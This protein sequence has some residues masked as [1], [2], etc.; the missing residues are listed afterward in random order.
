[1]EPRNVSWDFAPPPGIH[2]RPVQVTLSSP[3]PEGFEV[4]FTIDGTIPGAE[5]PRLNAPL[6]IEVNT[7]IRAAAFSGGQRVTRVTAAS[8]FIQERPPLPLFSIAIDPGKAYKLYFRKQYG[9]GKLRAPLF[10]DS[11]VR[12]FDALV[13]RSGYNDRFR[14]GRGDYN[15]RAA[16]LRDEVLREVHRDMGSVAVR[17][18]WCLL[19]VNME[20]RGLYNVVERPGD[21]FLA[22]HLGGGDW[23][24]IKTGDQVQSGSID[25]WVALLGV[26]ARSSPGDED[27]YREIERRVDLE[28]FTAYII[29]NHW[30]Q[31]H[32]WSY[33]NWY[34]ARKRAAGGRWIFLSWDAEWGLGLRP[35]G[36]EADS[37]LYHLAQRNS[38]R[39]LLAALLGHRKYRAFFL[40]KVKEHL[41]GALRPEKVLAHLARNREAIAPVMEEELRRFAGGYSLDSWRTNVARAESFARERGGVF[42]RQ[43]E[44]HLSEPFQL[45]VGFAQEVDFPVFFPQGA[46]PAPGQGPRVIVPRTRLRIQEEK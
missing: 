1:V 7:L 4:R 16:Y 14:A 40:E 27:S 42:L 8:Y 38:I 33:N 31:N 22:S 45:P 19:Y 32:D 37:F 44:S 15:V 21:E 24:V 11:P 20:P 25:E 2:P 3:L 39:D 17:G 12:E 6:S 28:N 36:W 46:V 34:A 26:V 41:E 23:D 5:S 30:A 29:L 18:S 9:K 35:S 10:P 13:L 43:M